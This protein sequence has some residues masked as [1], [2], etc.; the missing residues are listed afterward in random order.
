MRRP[1]SPGAP[2]RS[3]W[4]PSAR[5]ATATA[6]TPTSS[7]CAGP[8][9]APGSSTPS[10]APTCRASTRPSAT[11]SG[12]CT[13]PPRTSSASPRSAC[14]PGALRHRARRP[15]GRA[16]PR[17][18]RRDGRALPRPAPRQ[19]ALRRR[20]VDAAAPRAVAAVC[21]PR[22]RGARRRSATPCASDLAAQGKIAW[23]TEEFE[24]P[25]RL[26]RAGSARTTRG[27]ARPACT[28]C[29]GSAGPRSSASCG[30]CGT[31]SPQ[32]RDTAPGRVLPDAAIVELALAHQHATAAPAHRRLARPPTRTQHQTQHRRR[33]SRRS[34]RV[35]A[36]PDSDLPPVDPAADRSAASQGLG[37]PRPGRCRAARP[38]PRAARRRCRTSSPCR[39][40][41]S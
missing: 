26:H 7:S 35:L 23:A 11:P 40:R 30:R 5:R 4:T 34:P 32:Q 38:Q 36:L 19:G 28:R 10:P 21:R 2:G 25:A 33:S 12:S 14:G 6:S 15:P 37:R 1:P 16:P 3:A 17:R 22:R 9:P 8:A 29:A 31:A 20:L 41:T 27:G 39:W 13:P 18:P 24:S